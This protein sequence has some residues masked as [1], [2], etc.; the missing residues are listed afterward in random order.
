MNYLVSFSENS[1]PAGTTKIHL[2]N[3]KLVDSVG[4]EHS[5]SG[6]NASIESITIYS[7]VACTL[8]I[9]G[10]IDSVV[11][12]PASKYVRLKAHVERMK[13]ECS[14][15]FNLWFCGS[16]EATGSPEIT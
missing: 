7:S 8:Y 11:Y 1:L 15:S 5:M 10:D 12:L 13:I 3:G 4:T 14:S 2:D 6:S 16:S 9:Q